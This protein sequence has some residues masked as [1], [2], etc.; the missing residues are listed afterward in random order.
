M[1]VIS[2]SLW[3]ALGVFATIWTLVW[4]LVDDRI[5]ASSAVAAISWL[6]WSFVGGNVEAVTSSG[7]TVAVGAPPFEYLGFIMFALSALALFLNLWGVYPPESTPDRMER[8][9]Q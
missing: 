2:Q 6:V 7:G 5:T 8:D 1:P 4:M 9:I 3:L